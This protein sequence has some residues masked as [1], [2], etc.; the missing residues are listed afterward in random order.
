MSKDILFGFLRVDVNK[1]AEYVPAALIL[2]FI[3][4]RADH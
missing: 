3:D 1:P 4:R 2:P